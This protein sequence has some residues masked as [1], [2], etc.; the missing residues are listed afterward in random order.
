MNWRC[1]RRSSF[2]DNLFIVQPK[3]LT[4]AMTEL[5]EPMLYLCKLVLGMK[6]SLQGDG[7][8]SSRFEWN[9]KQ[10]TSILFIYHFLRYPTTGSRKQYWGCQP[11]KWPI[12]TYPSQWDVVK[13]RI[14]LLFD[15]RWQW[16]ATRQPQRSSKQRPPCQL[17]QRC[18]LPRHHG[19]AMPGGVLCRSAGFFFLCSQLS[20]WASFGFFLSIHAVSVRDLHPWS[21]IHPDT[22]DC[23]EY[24]SCSSSDQQQYANK[25]NTSIEIQSYPVQT[26]KNRLI[27]SCSIWA[28]HTRFGT[29]LRR[30][31][32]KWR[33]IS[34][35]CCQ[36]G[37]GW[38]YP[39]PKKTPQ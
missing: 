4:E 29:F 9:H 34:F 30:P 20:S 23:F 21:V 37:S 16:L 38:N 36:V 18:Q 22:F 31:W 5:N 2:A 8:Y 26:L 25:Q 10:L 39:F 19:A 33:L 28:T 15:N 35:W 32:T 24:Q 27:L 1:H 6:A 14:L 11:P 7:G 12:G 3:R 13:G 17:W